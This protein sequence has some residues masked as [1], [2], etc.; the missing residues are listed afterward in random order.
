MRAALL[1]LLLVAT[2]PVRAQ[3][4][5]PREDP[6]IYDIVAA[7]SAERLRADVTKLVGFGTRHTLSDTLSDTRGIGA[8]RR[9]I[10]AEFDRISQ[11]CGGCLEV[12]YVAEVFPPARRLPDSTNIVNVVALQRGTT[13]PNRMVIMSGDIDNIIS[14]GLGYAPTDSNPGANDNASGMAG[15]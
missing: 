1:P 14:R 11:E 10:K 7:V 15:T 6:R 9:W 4:A 13:D 12:F 2:T 5:P 8:A 3:Q